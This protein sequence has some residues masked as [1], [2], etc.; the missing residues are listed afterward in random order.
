MEQFPNE[1]QAKDRLLARGIDVEQSYRH[2]LFEIAGK[3]A[4]QMLSQGPGMGDREVARWMQQSGYSGAE[5]ARW[6]H[7]SRQTVWRW[8]KDSGDE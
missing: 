1:Q 8:L 7:V 5:I 3:Q 2:M 6:L 4:P